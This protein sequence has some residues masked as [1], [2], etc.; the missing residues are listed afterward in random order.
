MGNSGVTATQIMIGIGMV[1]GIVAL[2][3]SW[4]ARAR[5]QGTQLVVENL[6][7]Q[8][9]FSYEHADQELPKPVSK[10]L[11]YLAGALKRDSAPKRC[12]AYVTGAGLLGDA[13]GNAASQRGFE[14]GQQWTDPR[15]GEIRVDLTERDVVNLA[16]LSHLGF[17]QM[18]DSGDAYNF[19]DEK[20][21]EQAS[22]AIRKLERLMPE[23]YRD[24]SDPY[25]QAFNRSTMTWQRFQAVDDRPERLGP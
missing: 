24:P 13:M 2:V 16:I 20:D 23:E 6:A 12:D 22:E 1:W 21:A 10:A 18:I 25:A 15:V 3:R 7:R 5:L 19:K 14:R 17:R 8:C 4:L 9:S 11:D